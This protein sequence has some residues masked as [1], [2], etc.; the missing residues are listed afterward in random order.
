MSKMCFANQANNCRV[1]KVKTCVGKG[2]PFLKTRIQLKEGVKRA[3]S[4]LASL[5]ISKQNH[6]ANRYHEGNYPWRKDGVGHNS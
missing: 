5:D 4:R 1:L 6:I 2:C 3:N